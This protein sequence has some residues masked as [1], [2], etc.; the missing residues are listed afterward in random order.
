MALCPSRHH[1]WLVFYKGWCATKVH[2][3]LYLIFINDIVE[4]MNSFIRLFA[5]DTNL[6]IADDPL[7]SAI[8]L[9][10]NLSRIDIGHLCGL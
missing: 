6:Y 9:N 2:S 10:T 1:V 4:V 3:L 8:K 5:D 7:T